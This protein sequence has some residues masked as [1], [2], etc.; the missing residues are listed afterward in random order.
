MSLQVNSITAAA[1]TSA[2]TCLKSWVQRRWRCWRRAKTSNPG[3]PLKTYWTPPNLL[4][5]LRSWNHRRFR[6]PPCPWIHHLPASPHPPLHPRGPSSTTHNPKIFS[7][8]ETSTS[9][10]RYL[11]ILTISWMH[12]CL[13]RHNLNLFVSFIVQYLNDLLILC[14]LDV[15]NLPQDSTNFPQMDVR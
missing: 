5:I 12:W 13:V 15:M 4:C 3:S 1:L 9:N 7:S 2:S 6:N 10:T 8:L 14:H 11:R